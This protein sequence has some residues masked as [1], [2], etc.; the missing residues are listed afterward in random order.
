MEHLASGSQSQMV[1]EWVVA[2]AEW[3]WVHRAL[4]PVDKWGAQISAILKKQKFQNNGY[5]SSYL[6][7]TW[8]SPVG[9]GWKAAGLITDEATEF[10]N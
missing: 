3:I 9:W 1:V 2:M 7:G 8:G 4:V 10:F 6:F 5:L